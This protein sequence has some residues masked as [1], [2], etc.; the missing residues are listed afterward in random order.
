MLR[1]SHLTRPQRKRLLN[2]S[3]NGLAIA[4]ISQYQRHLSP[5]KGFSCAHRMAYGGESCSQHVKY[6]IATVGLL[7]AMALAPQRFRACGQ[8]YR[9]LK[10][11]GGA[12]REDPER[13][14]QR[15]QCCSDLACDVVSGC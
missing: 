4:A 12:T 6:L 15:A 3:L 8:A 7:E 13:L 2:L 1:P 11:Q 5:R 9:L 10:A 14:R